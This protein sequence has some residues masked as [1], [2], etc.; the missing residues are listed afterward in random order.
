MSAPPDRI[1]LLIC[2]LSFCSSRS[3]TNSRTLPAWPKPP[4]PPGGVA[5]AAPTHRHPSPGDHS[6]AINRLHSPVHPLSPTT[7]TRAA[8]TKTSLSNHGLTILAPMGVGRDP[9]A[10]AEIG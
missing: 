7:S 2:C 10:A 4:D 6:P 1:S 9:Y 3:S 5:S 8:K